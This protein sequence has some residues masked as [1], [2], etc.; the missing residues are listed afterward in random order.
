MLRNQT[1]RNSLGDQTLSQVNERTKSH[2][3]AFVCEFGMSYFTMRTRTFLGIDE[4]ARELRRFGPQS[5]IKPHR[6]SC[7]LW[8]TKKYR[9]K[10]RCT[11]FSL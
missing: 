1:L 7:E 4:K 9:G 8:F 10:V 3:N 2:L 6:P 5:F 11:A